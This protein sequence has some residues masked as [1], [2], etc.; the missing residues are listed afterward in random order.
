MLKRLPIAY[1]SIL[2]VELVGLSVL[3][4]L[5]MPAS[6]SA[7]GTALGWGALL[8]MIVMLVYSIARRSRA[9]RNVARLS[10]WLHFHI[11]LGF[12][13][14]LFAVFHSMP[15][16]AKDHLALLNPGLLSFVAA[17][18]VFSSGVFGRWLF[19]RLPRGPDG[20]PIRTQRVFALWIILHRPLAAGMYVLAFMHVALSYMFT[21]TLAG[22]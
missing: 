21:P 3:Y 13:G 19:G 1:A 20:E 8:S 16:F 5:R 9:L 6:S 7:I 18:V 11:F 10:Y 17:T 4:A 12:Q 2:I 15:L 14:F 22:G